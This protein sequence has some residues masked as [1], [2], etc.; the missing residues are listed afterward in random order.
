MTARIFN[1]KYLL[2][3]FLGCVLSRI[4]SSIFYIED[5][6]SLRFA[7]SIEE[8][9]IIKLQPHFPGYPIFCFL[10]KFLFFF[11]N[12]KAISF[13]IIGGFSL[14]I[15]IYFTL[16]LFQ[17]RNTIDMSANSKKSRLKHHCV[18]ITLS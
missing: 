13:S 16:K 4:A 3:L 7:L 2:F 11:T 17:I 9:N 15:I 10:A 14:F 12:S 1:Q 5:I 6:D 18:N 8:Y